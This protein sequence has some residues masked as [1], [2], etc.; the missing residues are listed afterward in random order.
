MKA[1]K[2]GY[3][4]PYSR[5]I[6]LA[7][8]H[9][10]G[11]RSTEPTFPEEGILARAGGRVFKVTPKA[12]RTYVN[13]YGLGGDMPFDLAQCLDHIQMELEEA[14]KGSPKPAYTRSRMIALESPS[15][16]F[17]MVGSKIMNIRI[18]LKYSSRDAT[19]GK[20]SSK[21]SSLVDDDVVY[22][23]SH[24]ETDTVQAM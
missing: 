2:P 21:D 24:R 13:E 14:L 17:K 22:D 16:V 8:R 1:T 20:D 12:M 23:D 7:E 19:K 4:H 15:L 9:A 5:E 11:R 3:V 6:S 10:N 18:S